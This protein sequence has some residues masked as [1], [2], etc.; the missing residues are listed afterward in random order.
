MT[1]A[2]SREKNQEF[3]KLNLAQSKTK[4]EKEKRAFGA[5]FG[6]THRSTKA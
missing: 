6:K 5:E 3:T 2:K 4:E 1:W